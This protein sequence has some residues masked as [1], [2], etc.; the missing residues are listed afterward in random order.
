VPSTRLLLDPYPKTVAFFERVAQ[1]GQGKCSQITSVQALEIAKKSKAVAIKY[2]E[3]FET[4]GIA[5][6]DVVQVMPVDYG[7]DPVKGELV[8]CSPDEI[9]VRRTDPRA[10]TVVVHFPRFG[11]Q[12]GKAS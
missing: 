9:A 1:F 8:H 5:L 11:Y 3:A 6:G 7:F 2:P 4:D 10:G 12:V